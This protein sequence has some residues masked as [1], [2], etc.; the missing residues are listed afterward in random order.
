MP[1][2]S[3]RGGGMRVTEVDRKYEVSADFE[4]PEPAGGSSELTVDEPVT[5]RLTAMDYDTEG[6][7]L[8]RHGVTLRHRTGGTDAGWHLKRPAAPGVRT[9][10]TRC[11]RHPGA[12]GHRP[13]STTSLP[14]SAVVARSIRSSGCPPAGSSEPCGPPTK[15]WSL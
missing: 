15:C 10:S 2:G 3:G 9:E 14:R 1:A 12:T 6:F 11:A 13:R 5:H 4:F 8:A 7:T